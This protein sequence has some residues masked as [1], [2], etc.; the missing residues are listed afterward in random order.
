M[1]IPATAVVLYMVCPWQHQSEVDTA[2]QSPQD[3]SIAEESDQRYSTRHIG[4]KGC[5]PC[6]QNKIVIGRLETGCTH[7]LELPIEHL[8]CDALHM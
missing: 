4:K 8:E 6:M 3:R 7:H 5:L 2:Q 1:V